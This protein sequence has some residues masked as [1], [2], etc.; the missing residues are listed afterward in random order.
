MGDVGISYH[1][2]ESSKG[3]AL[4]AMARYEKNDPRA[5]FMSV[6]PVSAFFQ[7]LGSKRPREKSVAACLRPSVVCIRAFYCRCFLGTL[8]C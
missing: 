5:T 6:F 4:A 1:G 3:K 2:L 8:R 7:Y